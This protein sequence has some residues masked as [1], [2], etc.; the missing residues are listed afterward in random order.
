[1]ARAAAAVQAERLMG[2]LARD[3]PVP[4]AAGAVENLRINGQAARRYQHKVMAV[5]RVLIRAAMVPQVVV[6]VEVWVPMARQR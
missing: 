6:A 4:P 2:R 3:C 5:V 1:M